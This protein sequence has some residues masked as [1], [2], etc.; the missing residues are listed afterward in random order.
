MAGP[1]RRNGINDGLVCG[2]CVYAVVP[3]LACAVAMGSRVNLRLFFID[4]FLEYQRRVGGW[5]RLVD[6]AGVVKLP[7]TF[8]AP[9]A[10]FKNWVK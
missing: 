1:T 7:A 2:L 8:A 9:A 4:E 3:C 10:S 5:G 6:F